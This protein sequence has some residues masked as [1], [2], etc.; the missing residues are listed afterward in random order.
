MPR[1]NEALAGSLGS[2]VWIVGARTNVT[3]HVDA[4]RRS[5]TVGTRS[6]A[7]ILTSRA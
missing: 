7:G 5:P 1:D 2:I 4:R 6:Q 3:L